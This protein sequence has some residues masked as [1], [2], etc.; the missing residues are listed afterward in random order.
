MR[1]LLLCLA[2]IVGCITILGS[3]VAALSQETLD[4]NEVT[5]KCSS[6]DDH[7]VVLIPAREVF[8]RINARVE[9]LSNT[10]SLAISRDN[11]K[12]SLFIN[13]RMADINGK[14]FFLERP[15]QLINGKTFVPM[16]LIKQAYGFYAGWDKTS[17]TVKIIKAWP[18][19]LTVSQVSNT[20]VLLLDDSINVKLAGIDYVNMSEEGNNDKS[21]KESMMYLQNLLQGQKVRVEYINENGFDKNTACIFTE[22]GLFVN[23]KIIADGYG[24]INNKLPDKDVNELFFK[25]QNQAIK[26]NKGIWYKMP[27]NK[28]Q[29]EKVFKLFIKN[30]DREDVRFKI[31][32]DNTILHNGTIY[33]DS[34]INLYSSLKPGKHKFVLETASPHYS[35][36]STIKKDFEVKEDT[37]ASIMFDYYNPGFSL[38]LPWQI[39]L[40]IEE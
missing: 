10:Q 21:Q 25:L 19:F 38:Q 4:F 35:S 29:T 24:K 22:R 15:I 17:R 2:V 3:L 6:L 12:I 8:E 9:W 26:D 28:R 20:N 11:V 7:G 5:I 39:T 27:E 32:V 36:F 40:T 18:K 34:A 13:S 37:L 33:P 16:E 30:N 1:K 31:L 14:Q 23:A